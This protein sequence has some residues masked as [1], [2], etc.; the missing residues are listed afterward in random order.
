MRRIAVLMPFAATD[1][2]GQMRLTALLETLQGLGW[3]DGKKVR[4]ELRWPAGDFARAKSDAAELI[5]WEP[6]AIVTGSNPVVAELL[7][8]TRTIPIV[9]C[10]VSDPVAGGFVRSLARPGGNVTG[11]T[12]FESGM[13]SK[14]LDLLKEIAPHVSRVGVLYLPEAPSH[15][16]MLRAAEAAAGPRAVSVSGLAVRNT[17]QLE[18]AITTFA[19]QGDSGLVVLPHP[20]YQAGRE[21]IAELALRHR[22]PVI[23]PFRYFVVHGGLVSYGIDQIDQWRAA[24]G[25]VDRILRGEKPG[26][27]PVQQP[28]K[29][30]LVVNLKTAKEMNLTIPESFLMRAD[31]VI[32]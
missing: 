10:Q 3:I 6:D 15:V 31:E 17:G 12:N 2:E 14:W 7:R 18:R 11:F 9:F 21:L 32:E 29:F 27:L 30:Q 8:L 4:I 23:Y 25:Y 22:L 26:Y 16:E 5:S 1:P 24:A 20:I 28:T 13:G 19:S